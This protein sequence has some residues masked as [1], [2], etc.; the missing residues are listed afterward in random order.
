LFIVLNFPLFKK[1]FLDITESIYGIENFHRGQR[2]LSKYV[3]EQPT[4]ILSKEY[5][6]PI[7]LCD[8]F[9]ASILD[10]K[11]TSNILKLL[12]EFAPLESLQHLKR[13]KSSKGTP[14]QW[15]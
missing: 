8:V 5:T 7:S 12:N 6:N 14:E 4:A 11:C 15:I 3:M 10:K 1:L 2:I 13:I 9:V